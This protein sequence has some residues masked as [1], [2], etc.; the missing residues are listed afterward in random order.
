MTD[1]VRQIRQERGKPLIGIIGATSPDDGYR[2]EVGIKAGYMLRRYVDLTEG[3]I[4][5]GGVDGVGVDVY[6]GVMRFCVEKA[7]ET[8]EMPDDKFFVLVPE[9]GAEGFSFGD[10]EIARDLKYSPPDAY[11]ALAALTPRRSLDSVRAG[12]D[13]RERREHMAHVSDVLVVINGGGGTLHEAMHALET[14][15]RVI[16]IK[17]TGGV[18]DSLVSI[19][20]MEPTGTLRGILSRIGVLDTIPTDLIYVAK[21]L[22]EMIPILDGFHL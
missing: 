5:T 11:T 8:G 9:T 14:S 21:D 4:F 10:G 17:G 2:R 1:L 22:D 16:A 13:M 19:K 7:A 20:G 3:R 15:R 18:A 6:I 12:Y